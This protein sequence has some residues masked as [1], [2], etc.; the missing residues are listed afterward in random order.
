MKKR[1]TDR[2]IQH[3]TIHIEKETVIKQHH[4]AIFEQIERTSYRN[5]TT[6]NALFS[7]ASIATLVANDC[8]PCVLRMLYTESLSIEH[9]CG[10]YPSHNHQSNSKRD[11][12]NFLWYLLSLKPPFHFLSILFSHLHCRRFLFLFCVSFL[13]YCTSHF[14]AMVLKMPHIDF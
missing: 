5:N 1:Q 6:F 11:I 8:E 13:F 14:I 12:Y 4:S 2:K 7:H 3:Q 9:G 10:W